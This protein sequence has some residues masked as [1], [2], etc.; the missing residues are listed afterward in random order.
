MQRYLNNNIVHVHLQYFFKNLHLLIFLRKIYVS[1]SAKFMDLSHR[2]TSAICLVLLMVIAAQKT[3]STYTKN[4]SIIFFFYL[5]YVLR[6]WSFLKVY[7]FYI[8]IILFLGKNQSRSPIA[9]CLRP[10]LCVIRRTFAILTLENYL[11]NAYTFGVCH[12]YRRNLSCKILGQIKKGEVFKNLLLYPIFMKP[13][14]K[15][16]NFMATVS[17]VQTLWW[18]QYYHRVKMY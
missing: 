9:I 13:L 18:G 3:I 5:E 1:A 15:L 8:I 4:A 17:V 7:S 14:P 10:S 16:L 6:V 11:T 12:I 2:V